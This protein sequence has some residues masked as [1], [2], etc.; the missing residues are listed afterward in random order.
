MC[1]IN[2]TLL[3]FNSY[4]LVAIALNELYL[5]NV[6]SFQLSWCGNI[7]VPSIQLLL[8]IFFTESEQKGKDYVKLQV[9]NIMV[10]VKNEILAAKLAGKAKEK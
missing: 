2:K 6:V 10:G 3:A 4:F 5:T 7:K 8:K 1:Q 9:Q